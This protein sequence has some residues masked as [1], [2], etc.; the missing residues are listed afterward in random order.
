MR[1]RSADV[2]WV[3]GNLLHL[4]FPAGAFALIVALD[5]VDQQRIDAERA[6][7]LIRTLLRPGG[8]TL[9]RVSAH[10][11]CLKHMTWRLA[12]RAAMAAASSWR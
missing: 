10:Q 4:P 7:D 3:Q 2:A 6:L 12:P 1:S 8:V 5:V 9:L 11:R